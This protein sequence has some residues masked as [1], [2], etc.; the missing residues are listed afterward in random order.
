[1]ASYVFMSPNGR[2]DANLLPGHLICMGH[3]HLAT[4]ARLLIYKTI[5]W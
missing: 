2:G 4:L 3:V 1:M 5:A